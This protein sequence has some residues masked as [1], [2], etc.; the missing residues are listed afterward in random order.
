MFFVETLYSKCRLPWTALA[1]GQGVTF[2]N[3]PDLSGQ[4]EGRTGLNWQEQS[5]HLS[6]SDSFTFKCQHRLRGR[7]LS[8]PGA[9]CAEPPS[10]LPTRR[11]FFE[12]TASLLAVR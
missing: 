6:R 5:T 10:S 4:R 9:S 1:K 8:L 2:L 11:P 3:T 12:I 7:A